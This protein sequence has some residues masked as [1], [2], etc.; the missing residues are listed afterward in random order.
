MSRHRLVPLLV[1]I[2]LPLLL[3]ADP[4]ARRGTVVP[5]DLDRSP[6]SLGISPDGRFAAT[7]NATADS[8]SL[9]DLAAGRVIAEPV[10]GRRP[11]DVAWFDDSTLLVSLRDDDAV[12]VLDRT[13]AGL[14]RRATIPVGDSPHGLALVPVPGG[15]PRV[16]VALAGEDAV[17]ELDLAGR[18]VIRHFAAGGQPRWIA[19]APNGRW[20]ITCCNAP[21]EVLVHEIATGKLI[22]RRTLFDDAFNLGVPVVLPD[23][24]TLIIPH[25][26]NRSFPVSKQNVGR[27]WVIDNRLTKLPLPEGKYWQQKQMNLDERGA[28]C[29]DVHALAL[30]PD[31]RWLV[32]TCGGSH[33]LLIMRFGE[34]PWPSADPGDFLPEAMRDNQRLFRRVELGG[35]PLGVRFIDNRRVVVAN[36]FLNSLQIVDVETAK[37]ERSIGL[38]GPARP[39]LVRR[40]EQLFFDADRSLDSWFSCHSCHTD[41]HTS[42]QTFDTLND[43]NYDTYK[44]TPSLRGVTRTGPW[45]WHGWQKSLEASIRKSLRDTLSTPQPPTDQDIKA[46]LAYLGTLKHPAS[47]HRDPQGRLTE[48]ARRGRALFSGKAACID[49][50][51]GADFT[52]ADTFVVGL[53][54]PRYF[55]PEFNPPSLRGLFDKRRFLHDGRAH[56]LHE[57]LTRHHRPEQLLGEK[58]SNSELADLIAYLKSL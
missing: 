52:T 50:H 36:Y 8:V 41:G 10:C 38:G 18:R 37:L 5:A 31:N 30:S 6:M 55:F 22:S 53:E 46:L 45:T 13:S 29:G 25:P 7:A 17:A 20:L 9:V 56:S 16:F 57:I 12:A 26:I 32:A 39:D 28:G 11:I 19:A 44:L 48:A 24:S 3:S 58:L 34:L 49:C 51:A 40:G 14:V 21:G 47:P 42:A 23:S 1:L 33:E 43:G 27:G 15:R 54:S 2:G 35:R 4:A